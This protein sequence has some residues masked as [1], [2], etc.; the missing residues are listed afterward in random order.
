[1]MICNAL[2]LISPVSTSPPGPTLSS[3]LV[4]DAVH[5]PV[6]VDC[7]SRAPLAMDE[8]V[9]GGRGGGGIVSL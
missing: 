2:F 9:A 1:M 7:G 8:A 5:L 6:A 3:D 4:A